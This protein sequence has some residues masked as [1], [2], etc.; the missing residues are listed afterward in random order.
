ML[1]SLLQEFLLSW[2]SFSI[3]NAAHTL[4]VLVHI[5]GVFAQQI[6]A[7]VK[8]PGLQPGTVVLL[9]DLILLGT[10]AF[11]VSKDT[12]SWPSQQINTSHRLPGLQASLSLMD[13]MCVHE[14]LGPE[15]NAE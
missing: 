5:V 14:I 11:D 15:G 8:R 2:V 12:L 7:P 10:K 4:T 13:Y 3:I 1:Q 9:T 6:T